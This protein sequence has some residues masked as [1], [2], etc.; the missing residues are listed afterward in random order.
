MDATYSATI[1]Y[2][3]A[4]N[5]CDAIVI[6][7]HLSIRYLWIDSLCII[8]DSEEDWLLHTLNL[9]FDAAS[10]PEIGALGAPPIVRKTDL[11]QECCVFTRIPG[12]IDF[13]DDDNR[14]GR[15]N[16]FNDIGRAR[17]QEVYLHMV[18]EESSTFPVQFG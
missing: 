7:T 4:K 2:S 3:L 17:S 5:F 8:Q 13:E 1:Q 10:S 15:G 16:I 11:L 6:Y 12:H 18:V 9:A 14:R